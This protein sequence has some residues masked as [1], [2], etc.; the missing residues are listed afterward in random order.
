VLLGSTAHITRGVIRDQVVT[1]PLWRNSVMYSSKT[2]N[3]FHNLGHSAS[4]SLTLASSSA[5]AKN[6]NWLSGETT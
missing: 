3:N 2:I 1:H 5:D 6:V 4:D